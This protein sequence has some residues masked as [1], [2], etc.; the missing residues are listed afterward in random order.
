MA[1][2]I[3]RSQ[4]AGRRCV[5][6]RRALSELANLDSRHKLAVSSITDPS[7]E[8][9]SYAH[10]SRPKWRMVELFLESQMQ[11]AILSRPRSEISAR[12][13]AAARASGFAK[14][15]ELKHFFFGLLNLAGCEQYVRLNHTV[16][17]L[18]WVSAV[19][20]LHRRKHVRTNVRQYGLYRLR[21]RGWLD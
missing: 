12:C 9:P 19:S 17:I 2:G 8:E 16:E 20:L 7:K 11:E 18:T 3:E 4:C 1:K 5:L 21:E 13:S 15:A 14:P 6:S 10:E